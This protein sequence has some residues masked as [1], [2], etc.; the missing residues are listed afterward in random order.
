MRSSTNTSGGY[1]LELEL[2]R[3]AR[4]L[5]RCVHTLEVTH[6]YG[7][8]HES[9]WL[10]YWIDLHIEIELIKGA[11]M[12]TEQGKQK[13]LEALADR[14]KRNADIKRIDNASLPAGSPMYFYCVTCGEEMSVPEGY[15][16][17]S[18]TCG[19][20]SALKDLGWLE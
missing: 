17:R 1:D 2:Q 3:V 9:V 6:A 14:R 19:E 4:D 11:K 13:A 18:K 7:R 8:L 16:S 12:K 10:D 20:C 5:V 15:T